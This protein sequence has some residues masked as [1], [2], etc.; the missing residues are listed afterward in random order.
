MIT[1]AL[2]TYNRPH[3]L[4]NAID[5]ILNQTF[6]DFELLICD[7]GSDYETYLVIL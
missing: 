2:L 7:N 6:K 5:G 3:F 4:K 1:I